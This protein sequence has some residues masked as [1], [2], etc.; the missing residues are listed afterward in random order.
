[1]KDTIAVTVEHP[2]HAAV[3]AVREALAVQGFGVLTEVD[4]AGTL[5]SKLGVDLPAQT[6]LGAC[7]PPLALRALQAEESIGVLLPCNIT[8]RA[9]AADRTLIETLDPMAMVA[10][11]DNE[12]LRPV[13]DEA[14]TRLRAALTAVTRA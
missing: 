4:L 14:A 3:A 9:I 11:T 8:I 10:V 12:R 13:A 7:N 5:H 1:M 6:I 2:F